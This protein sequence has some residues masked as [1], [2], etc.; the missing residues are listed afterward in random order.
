MIRQRCMC[1]LRPRRLPPEICTARRTSCEDAVGGSGFPKVT[2][3]GKE[4]AAKFPRT[5]AG[6]LRSSPTRRPDS[7]DDG[8]VYAFDDALQPREG[9]IWPIRVISLPGNANNLAV[10]P[11]RPARR[12]E[13]IISRGPIDAMESHP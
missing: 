13:W 6:K 5:P 2:R 4:S 3:T 1:F 8:N 12:K 7:R 11:V 10:L 9:S